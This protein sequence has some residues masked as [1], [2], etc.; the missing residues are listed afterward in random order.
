MARAYP[1]N[2][3]D[4]RPSPSVHTFVFHMTSGKIRKVS[5]DH[6]TQTAT[7]YEVRSRS[8]DYLLASFPV[9]DVVKWELSD[10]HG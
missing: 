10:D 2:I 6:V 9:K 8:E 3:M 1:V 4:N 7:H 5:G